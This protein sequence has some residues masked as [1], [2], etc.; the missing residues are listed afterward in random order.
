MLVYTHILSDG[1]KGYVG[2]YADPLIRANT[3]VSPY[4]RMYDCVIC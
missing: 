3:P 4:Q 2:T 1:R